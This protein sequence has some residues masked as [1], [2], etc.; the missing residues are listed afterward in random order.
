METHLEEG[1]DFSDG[2]VVTHPPA[3]AGD[4]G[5]VWELRSHMLWGN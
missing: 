1:W 3:S 5:L 2:P 4:T